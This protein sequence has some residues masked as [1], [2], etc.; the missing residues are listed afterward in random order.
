MI[1]IEQL[2]SDNWYKKKK[3]TVRVKLRTIWINKE[4]IKLEVA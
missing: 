3:R 1:I 2:F 4:Q